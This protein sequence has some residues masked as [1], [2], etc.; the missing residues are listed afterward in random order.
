MKAVQRKGVRVLVFLW[1]TCLLVLVN[2]VAWPA[3]PI[4]GSV[5]QVGNQQILNLWGTYYEMGY[6]HG[7]LMADKIRDLIDTY[8]IG[9]LASGNVADYKTL[10]ANDANPSVVQWQQQYLD[11]INGMADGMAASGKNLYVPSLGRNIDAR[12]I[13]AF[14]LFIEFVFGCSSFG[15]WGNATTN[16]ETIVARNMDFYYD[17]QGYMTNYQ[18]IIAYEPTGKAKFVSFAWPGWIGVSSGM[19]ESGVIV[20][21]NKGSGDNSTRGPFHSSI[22]VLRNILENTTP[23]NYLTRPLSLVNSVDEY[24]TMILQIGVPYIGSGN[25]VYFIEDSSSQNLIRYPADTDPSYNHIIA[26]N[27]FMKVL[28]PPASGDTVARYNSIRNGLIN[29]YRSGD[30]KVDSTEA[31][32]LLRGVADIVAPTLTSMVIRPN[33]MEFDLS[34]ATMDYG[35]FRS[36][37]AVQPQTYTW[38]SLFPDQEPVPAVPD[39]IVQSIVANPVSPQLNQPVNVTVSVKNQGGADAGSYYIEFYQS[40]TSAPTSQQAGD[41]TCGKS[42]L[43]AGATDSCTFTVMFSTAGS[44]KM[45]AQADRQQQVK[46]S[47]ETN[48]IFGPQTITVG[49][50]DLILSSLTAPTTASACQTLSVSDTTKNSGLVPA[51]AGSTTKFYWSTN[52]TYDAGDTYLGSRGIQALSAGG[53]SSGS[54]NMAIPCGT[55]PGTYYIIGR[56]DADNVIAE[57]NESN[58]DAYVSTTVAVARPDLTVSSLSASSTARACQTISVS[59]RTTNTGAGAA[60]AST[61]KFYWSANSTYDAGDTYL[62]SRGIKALSPGAYSSGST[63]LKIPCGIARGTYYVIGKAD[64]DGVVAETNE[65][66]NS[67][68]RSIRLW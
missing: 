37:T 66:N 41:A 63:S 58:N 61:T 33:R 9:T 46:E 18:V 62:G 11:E 54:T 13:R 14:N 36:A 68:V 1:V 17:D 30:R 53:Y 21:S 23:S 55:A 64:A 25:P 8:V 49:S 57:A 6:A 32:T 65:G 51:V 16:G 2:G 10:L 67:K 40:L 47:N 56:A 44:Y 50:P 42:G 12:D 48:N 3:T 4:N 35:T 27:H 45:W 28:P 20:T 19:N 39:L 5:R 26:T 31:W 22:E 52:S 24:T 43:A 29:L 59:D 60:A 15:V 7:Y 38:A 34:F